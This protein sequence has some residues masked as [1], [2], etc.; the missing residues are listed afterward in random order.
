MD[1]V[2]YGDNLRPLLTKETNMTGKEIARDC[3]NGST[4]YKDNSEGKGVFVQD[5]QAALED[6]LDEI[7]RVWQG[8]EVLGDYRYSPVL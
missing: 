1:I 7:E 3:G 2:L 6:D 8:L 4:A 5:M